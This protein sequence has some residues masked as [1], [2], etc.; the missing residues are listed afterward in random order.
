MPPASVVVATIII[1][2]IPAMEMLR[3]A[4]VKSLHPAAGLALVSAAETLALALSLL[5]ATPS[6]KTHKAVLVLLASAV[7]PMVMVM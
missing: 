1:P 6:L 7:A 4:A 3:L 2:P 5:R